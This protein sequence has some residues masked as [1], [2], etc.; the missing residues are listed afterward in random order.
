MAV[1]QSIAYAMPLARPSMRSFV[2]SLASGPWP[3]AARTSRQIA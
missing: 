1:T 3:I 2:S